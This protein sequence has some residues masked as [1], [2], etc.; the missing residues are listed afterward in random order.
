MARQPFGGLTFERPTQW[1]ER[2]ILAYDVGGL[3]FGECGSSL[4][5]TTEPRDPSDT[6]IGHVRRHAN[7]LGHELRTDKID[8]ACVLIGEQLGV[9][10]RIE[11][12]GDRGPVV[13]TS[14]YLANPLTITEVLV[15]TLVAGRNGPTPTAARVFDTL[16]SSIRVTPD[17]AAPSS[18]DEI[19]E[20]PV[21][22]PRTRLSRLRAG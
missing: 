4:V 15:F 9:R 1:K 6:L 16:L 22:L 17:G 7:R 20:E 3:S 14:A 8:V 12:D 11:W 10:L 13:Q 5:V 18:D 21:T 2:E 19:E